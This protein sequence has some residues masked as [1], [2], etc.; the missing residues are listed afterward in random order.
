MDRRQ[1]W[2]TLT[3]V[4]VA[5]LL[6][7]GVTLLV[8]SGGDD[9]E[10]VSAPGDSTTT[11]TTASTTTAST[12][13]TSAPGTTTIPSTTPTTITPGTVVVQT[14]TTFPP[15]T[16]VPPITRPTT[17]T[18]QAP[19]T[20]QPPTTQATTTQAPTT[21]A[22]TST[23]P[24]TTTT[25][26]PEPH[27]PGITSKEIRVAVIADDKAAVHGM[28][29]WASTINRKGGIAGRKVKL[30]PLDTD[31]TTEGYAEAMATACTRDF[32]IVGT[33][34][35]FDG[36]TQALVECKAPDL[37]TRVVDDAHRE[38]P[39]TFPLIPERPGVVPVG[40]FRWFLDNVDGCCKQL[41]VVPAEEPGASAARAAVTAST[42]VGFETLDTVDVAADAPESRYAEIVQQIVSTGADFVRG[43]GLDSTVSLRQEAQDQQV[44]TVSAWYCD[45]QCYDPALVADGGTAVEGQYV[46]IGVVPLSDTDVPGVKAFLK[47]MD[48][49]ERPTSPAALEAFASGLL[50]QRAARDA[51]DASDDGSLTRA[52]VVDA[53]SELHDFTALGIVGSTDIAARAP[54]GCFALL[55]VQSGELR[56]AYPA[57][58]GQLDCGAANL[59]TLPA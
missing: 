44:D 41:A 17:T 21:P 49:L 29:A 2:I 42:D 28:T 13:T 26:E 43:A 27:D 33:T 45:R 6:G 52:G 38:A 50:F 12:T 58:A 30:D 53:L 10:T 15:I 59:S 18:T 3:A 25:T 8:T 16:E 19:T 39:T 56:R 23:E 34:S 57:P 4:A 48:R 9:D 14:T 47:A 32:A 40:A 7:V 35:R 37:P 54:T 5:L 51:V 22:P 20:T 1:L 46:E 11:T 31:G 36:A 24:T 55:Q